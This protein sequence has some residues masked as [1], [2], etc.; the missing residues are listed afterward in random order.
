MTSSSRVLIV[1]DQ[2]GDISWLIDL[3]QDRGYLVVLATNEE[4][5]MKQLDA[6]RQG[7]ASYALAVI[8]VMVAL[9]D[10]SDLVTLD[11]EV[12]AASRDTGIRLCQIAR[13]DLGL[14]EFNLPI[15]CLT[16]REDN[17]VKAAM[18][19]LGIPL[20]NRAPYGPEESIREFI[21]TH[22]PAVRNRGESR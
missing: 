17:E 13:R 11:D 5:A 18:R 16:V 4:A 2:V 15:V 14:S 6:V 19:D 20:F 9:K 1:D 7:H 22:L 8:D 3:I 10:L 21:D 12:L